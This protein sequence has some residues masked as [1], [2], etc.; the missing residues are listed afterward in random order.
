MS[1]FR[2]R[3]KSLAPENPGRALD[4]ACAL[5]GATRYMQVLWR[6]EWNILG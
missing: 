4:A 6:R 2:S 5:S 1:S 3:S